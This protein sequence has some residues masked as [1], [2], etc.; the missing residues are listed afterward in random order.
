MTRVRSVTAAVVVLIVLH[1]V[2][3]IAVD[4]HDRP[5]D[6]RSSGLYY[7]V[8]RYME[9]VHASGRPYRD[10][11]VEYP[12]L[13]LAELELIVGPSQ[14]STAARLAWAQLGL[15]LVMLAGLAW[16]WGR[17]AVLGY[18]VLSLPLLV[19]PFVF[20]RSDMLAVTLAVL[21]VAALRRARA[22]T[23][24]VALVLGFFAKSWPVVLVPRL[25]LERRWRA[26]AAWATLTGIGLAAWVAWGGLGGVGDVV[27]F[28]GARGWQ[29][30]SL[31]GGLLQLVAGGTA[32]IQRGTYRIGVASLWART[33]L[34]GAGVV[35][36]A[37]IWLLADRR[38]GPG[39]RVLRDGVA[40]LAAVAALLLA[41]PLFSSQFVLWLVPWAAIIVAEMRVTRPALRTLAGR[42]EAALVGLVGAATV[43]T[44]VVF[45][46]ISALAQSRP[47]AVLALNGR[48]A[49]VIAVVVVGL[50]RLAAGDTVRPERA[51][52]A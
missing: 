43:G 50:W 15:E 42:L 2:A 16:G 37:L 26:L 4:L 19:N 18:L 49:L 31:P 48:N 3:V 35:V 40:P 7:D 41:S 47:L 22:G 10:F 51:A 23:G 46:R 14:P 29:V 28:R 11:A 32:R 6:V 24:A 21:G 45:W 8:P 30:E 39:S 9:I 13:T 33:G 27:T 17:R 5:S 36:V 52:V 34:A 25:A 44:V 38:S 12:P 1:V 20:T